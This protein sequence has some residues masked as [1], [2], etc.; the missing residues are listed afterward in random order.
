MIMVSVAAESAAVRLTLLENLSFY[1]CTKLLYHYDV[2]Q[3]RVSSGVVRSSTL[4]KS[5]SFQPSTVL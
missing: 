2:I 5:N 3:L 1:T 4:D